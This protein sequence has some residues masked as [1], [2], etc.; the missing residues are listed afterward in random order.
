MACP[1]RRRRWIPG[2]FKITVNL[3][4]DS[5]SRKVEEE[6]I[7]GGNTRHVITRNRSERSE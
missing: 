6:H 2:T 3:F 4:D 1:A 7:V 5:I